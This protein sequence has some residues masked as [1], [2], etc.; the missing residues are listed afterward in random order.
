MVTVRVVEVVPALKTWEAVGAV[1]LAVGGVVSDGGVIG[2]YE[3][4]GLLE[5]TVRRSIHKV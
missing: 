1:I 2:I 4:L 3:L 5:P